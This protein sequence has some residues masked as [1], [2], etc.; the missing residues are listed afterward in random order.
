MYTF[1]KEYFSDKQ[2]INKLKNIIAGTIIT[3]R[4]L[5]DQTV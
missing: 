2:G 3:R 5:L 1:I 4:A